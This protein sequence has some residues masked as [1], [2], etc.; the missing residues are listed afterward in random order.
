MTVREGESAVHKGHNRKTWGFCVC[1]ELQAICKARS[2]KNWNYPSR[3]SGT[4]ERG[5]MFH[6][7]EFGLESVS[8][9]WDIMR[10]L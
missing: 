3:F 9:E 2:G 4:K 6:V 1:Q 10:E 5:L 8:S 7:W